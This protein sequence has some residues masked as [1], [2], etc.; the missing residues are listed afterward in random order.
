MSTPAKTIVAPLMACHDVMDITRLHAASHL[1]DAHHANAQQVSSSRWPSANQ[2]SK[3][4]SS[5]S[6]NT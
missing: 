6:G 2:S 5:V 3:T 1:R 4:S